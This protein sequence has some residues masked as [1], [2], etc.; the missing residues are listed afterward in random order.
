MQHPPNN[1]L[2]AE[3][4]SIRILLADDHPLVRAGIRATLEMEPDLAVV[5]EVA[6]RSEVPTECQQVDP[7]IL[8]LDLSMP[9]PSAPELILMLRD[10]NPELKVLV[11]TAYAD[12]AQIHRLVSVGIVGY[13]L[14]S[15]APDCVVHAIRS[16]VA[17]GT[18]FSNV[19]LDK[20]VQGRGAG[21]AAPSLDELTPREQQVL[22]AIASGWDNARIAQ[23]LH[24]AEQTVRNYSSRIY[25]K[26]GVQSRGE[27]IVWALERGVESMRGEA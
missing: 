16:L 18:W 15:E 1:H 9:G 4:K 26:L 20:L 14:K 21:P 6:H 5:G 27:A 2:P 11:L 3:E 12:E 22:E 10:K 13:M 7:D 8:L 25:E 23:E 17:G 19:V 24:L